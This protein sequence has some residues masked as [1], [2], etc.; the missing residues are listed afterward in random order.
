ML[1][2]S[3]QRQ[4]ATNPE[5]SFIIQAPAGSGKT[6]LLTQR[7]LRLLARV[8]SPE[9]IVAL[10]FTRKAASEMRERILLALSRAAKN[11]NPTTAHQ[12]Q[13]HVY[14]TEALAR[15]KQKNWS[16]LKQPARLCI[17]TI[18]A[19][20]QMINQA[21]P[22]QEKQLAYARVTDRPE[23]HYQKAVQACLDHLMADK[24][25]HPCL[26]ILFSHLDNR[27]DK[28]M[29]LLTELLAS[30]DRWLPFL[31]TTCDQS[32]ATFERMLRRIEQSILAHFK[33]TIPDAV[34]ADLCR[35]SREIADIEGNPQSPR[36]PLRNWENKDELNRSVAQALAALLLTSDGQL[37]K[38][39]DHHIGLKRGLCDNDLYER[40]KSESAALCE[41]LSTT[42]DFLP[43]L[44]KIRD[45]PPV[46]YDDEQWE[47]LQALFTLLPLLVAHLHLSFSEA[48]ELDFTQVAQQAL[49]ALGEEDN[50]TDLALYFDNRISHL[51]IDEFQDTSISQFKLLAKLVHGWEAN[52]GRSLFVVGD[53]MQSIYR[54]RQA[55]VGLFLKAKQ[56]GIGPVQLNFLELCSNFRSSATIVDWINSQ[57]KA[58]FPQINQLE[59]GAIAFH[60]SVNILPAS[61]E[62]FIKAQQFNH[63]LD[64]AQAVAE[65]VLEQLNQFPTEQIAI[66]VR[67]RS[68]L[69]EIIQALR[70]QRIP[71]QG[72]DIEFLAK[73]PHLRDLWS[74][75]QALL[76]P[77]NRL[78]W[79]SLLR[80]PFCGLGLAELHRVANFAKNKSI[81]FALEHLDALPLAEESRLRL[82]FVFTVL[83]NALARRYHT[84]LATWVA[85]V[86]KELH[87]EQILDSAKQRD[88]EQFWVLLEFFSSSP[89][90]DLGQ[91][92]SEFNKLYSQ[93]SKAACVQVMTIHKAKGL[94]FDTVILPGLNA[95]AQNN[96]SPLLRWLN[97]PSKEEADLLLV[98]PIKAAHRDHCLIYNYL[99]R[100]DAEKDSYELQRLLYVAA[101]RAKKRL[102]LFSH[103]EK[104]V[105]GSFRGLLQQ[106]EFLFSENGFAQCSTM[107]PLPALYQLPLEFYNTPPF[108]PSSACNALMPPPN[109][110]RLVGIIVHELLQWICSNHPQNS[111]QLPWLMVINRLKMSGFNPQEL[112]QAQ[113]QIQQQ[114]EQLFQDPIG[115]WIIQAHPEE[116]NEYALLVNLEGENKTRIIDRTF[117][118]GDE[119]WI[120]DF[121]TGDEKENHTAHRQQVSEYAS[122]FF[123]QHKKI[124]CGLYYLSTGNWVSWTYATQQSS[125]LVPLSE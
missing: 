110:A 83:K 7:Y 41:T 95:R 74:L 56:K 50:P 14:A 94:E 57:F 55:E 121:K 73:L 68:Q 101:T 45:L 124:Q 19:L 76:M 26:K 78:A 38:K 75:T 88:L 35:L 28:L 125:S 119:R 25:S 107:T 2:D 64:E 102:Y 47:V 34:R 104:E 117:C 72:V 20:C 16:L 118:C 9:E 108:L 31:Y 21:I 80:S 82:Q 100:L 105:K 15:S 111:K 30:R 11:L 60:P 96:E 5:Q 103:S 114:I 58:I 93:H 85:N 67:S 66:L 51:L 6:E 42:T 24:N 90:P 18:D 106:Q 120:I 92:R 43:A 59:S 48:N 84:S 123:P 112:Y 17:M 91:F 122:Y 10:T 52:D 116:A 12:Q 4:Q 8:N 113:Q 87:G 32:Q 3:Q 69:T 40:L 99:A 81:Y 46:Y 36:S 23:Y 62:S 109:N 61:A 44:L 65:C 89:Y 53:P 1:K 33:E 54:F 39:F 98:S 37:R 27:Q 22:S 70:R 29:N 86:F 63:R 13:T 115:Q 97:L 79:L 71:F 77:A 49:F